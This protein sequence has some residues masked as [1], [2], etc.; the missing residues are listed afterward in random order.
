[1]ATGMSPT[2]EQMERQAHDWLQ[3]TPA[4]GG[5]T[6][7]GWGKPVTRTQRKHRNGQAREVVLMELEPYADQLLRELDLTKHALRRGDAKAAVK[8]ALAAGHCHGAAVRLVADANERSKQTKPG[9][10]AGRAGVMDDHLLNL[11]HAYR[12]QGSSRKA[13]IQRMRRE[14]GVALSYDAIKRRLMKRDAWTL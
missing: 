2:L 3:L 1:M 5:A 10:E 12:A 8:H 13:A 4:H 6:D 11:F 9:G 7:A 14:G